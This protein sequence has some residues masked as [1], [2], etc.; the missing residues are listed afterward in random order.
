M[1]LGIL[2]SHPIQ[3]YS[4]WFRALA[5]RL[6]LEVFYA[7]K[8]SPGQQADA[9]FGVPFEWDIDLLSGYSHTG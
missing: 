9:G 6:D 1:R 2:V 7:Y 4:P 8:G 3:Y 5:Q